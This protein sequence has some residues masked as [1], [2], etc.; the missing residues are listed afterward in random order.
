MSRTVTTTETKIF[1]DGA[2]RAGILELRS[3]EAIRGFTTNPTL[4]RAAATSRTTSRSR[5]MC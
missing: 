2:D 1:A 5:W 4:M 3:N